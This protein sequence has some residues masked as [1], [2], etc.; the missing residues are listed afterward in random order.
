MTGVQTCALPILVFGYG[1][2]SGKD[3]L[4]WDLKESLSPLGDKA[5]A[6]DDLE[7]LMAAVKQAAKPGD[8]ILVMSNGGFGG[9]HRKLLGMLQ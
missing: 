4:G 3:A 2:A 9:V 6:F 1:S 8:H 5:Q 7:K